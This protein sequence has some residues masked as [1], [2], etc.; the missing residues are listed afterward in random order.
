MCKLYV[1]GAESASLNLSELG[2]QPERQLAAAGAGGDATSAETA[3]GSA[4]PPHQ[5]TRRS[6][7][8]KSSDERQTTASRSEEAGA[9]A[10]LGS[11]WWPRAGCEHV[12]ASATYCEPDGTELGGG[13]G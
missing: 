1:K 3:P 2:L 5:K 4:M 12:S 13:G 8:G 10:G 11:S 9:E 7:S 6:K